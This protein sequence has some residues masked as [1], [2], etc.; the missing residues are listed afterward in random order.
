M[1][2]PFAVFG[3][4]VVIVTRTDTA[5]PV[6]VNVGYANE[7]SLDV[8]GST[9]GLFGQK[10]F[11]LAVARGTI[12]VTGKIKAATL[13]GLA[14]NCTFFGQSFAAGGD[15]YY[16]NEAHTVATTTQ[17]VTNVT[18]GI[19]D[20]GVTYAS[21]GLPLQRVASGAEATGKYS[22]NQ[23]TGTY[24]FAVGDEVAL[25]FSYSNAQTVTG[26]QLQVTNQMLGTNP[27]FQLD[28]YTSLNQPTAKPFGARLFACVADKVS[29]AT[30]LED[31]MMPE[32]DFQVF[33]NNSGNVMNFD[34]PEVS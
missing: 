24:T 34:F 33:A 17:I 10:Q 32:I 28:Y 23:T 26:Q 20:L 29:L 1:S 19:I 5:T 27:T 21:S 22:V 4:G 8:S 2:A 18:G 11:A 7:F 13:S 3:P 31:F 14:W 9:K 15:S 25:L 30:K 16:M 12:K 6:A